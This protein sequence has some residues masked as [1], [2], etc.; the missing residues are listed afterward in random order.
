MLISRNVPAAVSRR[1]SAYCNWSH[2]VQPCFI[3]CLIRC[4]LDFIVSSIHE[5][6]HIAKLYKMS[7]RC[8]ITVSTARHRSPIDFWRYST[9]Y[10]WFSFWDKTVSF[11]S[12]CVRK[13]VNYSRGSVQ[14]IGAPVKKVDPCC[15]TLDIFVRL[16]LKALS[17]SCVQGAKKQQECEDNSCQNRSRSNSSKTVNRGLEFT[18]IFKIM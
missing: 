17:G 3:V 5:T 18:P 1:W 7:I 8:I 4:S 10:Y 12:I 6:G 11:Y 15:Y 13:K 16:Y 14:E 2:L 9:I